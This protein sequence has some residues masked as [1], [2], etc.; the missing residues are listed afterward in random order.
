MHEGNNKCMQNAVRKHEGKGQ[1]ANAE[2]LRETV[3][4]VIRNLSSRIIVGSNVKLFKRGDERSDPQDQ[5]I[6]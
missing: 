2:Y 4:E 1:L 6:S 5:G 3:P